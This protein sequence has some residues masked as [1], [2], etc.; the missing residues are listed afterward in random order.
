[1]PMAS[2]IGYLNPEKHSR[3]FR[4]SAEGFWVLPPNRS[5]ERCRSLEDAG[6]QEFFYQIGEGTE[7]EVLSQSYDKIHCVTFPML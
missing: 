2:T 5:A 3:F 7:Q 1:M 4:E 6:R